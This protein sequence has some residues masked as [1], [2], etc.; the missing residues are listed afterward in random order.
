MGV[1]PQNTMLTSCGFFIFLI[2]VFTIGSQKRIRA[3]VLMC[4]PFMVTNRGRGILII[5]SYEFVT[6]HITPNIE[7]NLNSLQKFYEC[8]KNILAT[9]TKKAMSNT[10]F[11]QDLHR[12]ISDFEQ[13]ASTVNTYLK[14]I[15]NTTKEAMIILRNKKEKYLKALMV[16]CNKFKEDGKN[17]CDSVT[18]KV[19]NSITSSIA[20]ELTNIASF[21][22]INLKE[23]KKEFFRSIHNSLCDTIDSSTN[24]SF[25]ENELKSLKNESVAIWK[26]FVDNQ[27][28][29]LLFAFLMITLNFF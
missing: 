23:F 12:T 1:D 4:L 25:L 14:N 11:Y 18:D 6:F 3:I 2:Y 20:E 17:S 21:N 28:Q 9:E 29:A 7:N 19:V 22:T 15:K 27:V 16:S 8:N 26:H 24:C 5:N 13:K 10:E